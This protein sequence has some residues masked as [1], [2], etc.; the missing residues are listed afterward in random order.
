LADKAESANGDYRSG[1]IRQVYPEMNKGRVV[2]DID[3]EG[4]GDFFVGER[5]PVY[6]AAGTREAFV[7]PPRFLFEKYGVTYAQLKDV[8]DVVV[9]T[10]QTGSTGIEILSGL[11]DGD[12]LLAPGAGK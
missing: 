12:I 9:Q 4:L 6:V 11:R 10:G 1:K 8:G 7:V 2:A 3:V 5:I